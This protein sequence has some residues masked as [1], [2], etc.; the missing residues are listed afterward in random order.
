LLGWASAA[1]ARFGSN[2]GSSV[3]FI[4]KSGA[5]ICAKYLIP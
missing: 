1:H 3:A 2:A 4:G 5:R